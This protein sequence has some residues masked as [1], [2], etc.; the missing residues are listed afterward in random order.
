MRLS[1]WKEKKINRNASAVNKRYS[2]IWRIKKSKPPLFIHFRHVVFQLSTHLPFKTNPRCAIK[3]NI[4]CD[5]SDPKITVDLIPEVQG[6]SILFYTSQ[7]VDVFSLFTFHI[8]NPETAGFNT[9]NFNARH[10]SALEILELFNKH[11]TPLAPKE[12]EV[13]SL[14]TKS[15]KKK[16]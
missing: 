3:T 8:S 9:V 13:K 6:K 15:A 12:E 14:A 7:W 5:R 1:R 16:K 10:L 11:I 2:K 4:V